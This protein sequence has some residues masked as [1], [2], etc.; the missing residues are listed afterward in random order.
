MKINFDSELKSIKGE[1]LKNGEAAFTLKDASIE[2]LVA[3]SQDDRSDGTEKFKR[4]QLAVKVNAGGEI[5]IT[6]EESAMLKDRIGRL[7]GPVVIGPAFVL[8]NG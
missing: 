1:V 7:Y 5:E 8:L 2:A 3:M 4:Y 6:P